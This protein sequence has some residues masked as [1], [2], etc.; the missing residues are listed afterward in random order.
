MR[1]SGQ[2]DSQF[3]LTQKLMQNK[4]SEYMK[5]LY[6]QQEREVLQSRFQKSDVD[7]TNSLWQRIKRWFK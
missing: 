3:M 5:E 4:N 6:E 1:D 7:N 2:T